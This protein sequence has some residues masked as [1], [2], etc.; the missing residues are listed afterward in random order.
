MPAAAFRGRAVLNRIVEWLAGRLPGED[1]DAVLGDF[2]EAGSNHGQ[3]IRELLGLTFDLSLSRLLCLVVDRWFRA[4]LFIGP[5]D[6]VKWTTLLL[7]LHELV[8]GESRPVG[9]C[10][11]PGTCLNLDDPPA[12]PHEPSDVP[13]ARTLGY[14]PRLPQ[15]GAGYAPLTMPRGCDDNFDFTRHVDIR[16]AER[17]DG[18]VERRRAA[19]R[20]GS[21]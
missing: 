12:L 2:A 21:N 13:D 17:V 8:L 11:N 19:W 10:R 4:G 20:T 5:R 15:P 7:C 3:A 1:R 9:R 6:L 18:A 16:M 14:A